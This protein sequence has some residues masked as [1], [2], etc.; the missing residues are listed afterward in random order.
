MPELSEI[1]SLYKRRYSIEHSYRFDKQ[2]LLWDEP[3]LRTPEKMQTWTDIISAVHNEVTL[4]RDIMLGERLPWQSIRRP[5]SPQQVRRGCGGIIAQLGTPAA[6]PKV[7][8]KSP[9]RL[10]GT[11]VKKAERFE[12]V[13]KR[14]NN[15]KN[16]V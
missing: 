2:S 10:P 3:R 14:T 12:T 4:A 11:A 5:A 8:G 1:S 13:Y 15:K 9:G 7:R 6:P 16:L